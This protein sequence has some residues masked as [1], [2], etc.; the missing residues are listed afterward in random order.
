MGSDEKLSTDEVIHA[1]SETVSDLK[2][3]VKNRDLANNELEQLLRAEKENK[4]RK[5]ARKF[6][7]RKKR[8]LKEEEELSRAEEDIREA[9]ELIKDVEEEEVERK[10][11]DLDAPEIIGILSQSRQEIIEEVKEKKFSRE[12]LEELIESEKNFRDRTSVKQIF[13]QEIERLEKARNFSEAEADIKDLEE[14]LSEIEDSEAL[15]SEPEKDSEV[16]RKD[17]EKEDNTE[18]SPENEGDE[19]GSGDEEAEA[20]DETGEAEK[21]EEQK[22]EDAEEEEDQ[23][24]D[25]D[26]EDEEGSDEDVSQD[27][28]NQDTERSLEELMDE[29]PGEVLDKL[30]EMS[31]DDIE[32]LTFEEKL[33]EE[34]IDELEGDFDPAKLREVS[35]R[36]LI[37]LRA[38]LEE[39]GEM[40]DTNSSGRDGEN[41]DPEEKDEDGKD[42]EEMEE[43]AEEDLQMLMGAGISEETE[44]KDGSRLP[45]IENLK[46]NLRSR[47][48]RSGD[49]DESEE[50]S[51]SIN[52]KQVLELLKGYKDLPERE[53]AIKTAHI[54]KGYLEYRK[55]VERELTYSE[56]ADRLDESD[57]DEK[58]LADYF[59]KMSKDEYT[60]NVQID[61]KKIIETSRKVVKSL[62]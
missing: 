2:D 14:K 33:R 17:E 62:S 7:K 15:A 40:D 24:P 57:E 6:L 20:T 43:E 10:D 16:D 28:E 13:R 48:S 54:M 55:G 25:E 47:I 44:E 18:E 11:Y 61:S 45:D 37:K 21:D 49:E 12:N 50:T 31:M 52:E 30:D 59:N 46:E 8:V 39:N 27:E 22:E 1:T 23:E 26:T 35:T 19:E 56:L 58:K 36:D 41:G 42:K 53:A 60:G 32:K 34:L 29:K 3:F 51:E 5:T 9:E 38:E 4:D